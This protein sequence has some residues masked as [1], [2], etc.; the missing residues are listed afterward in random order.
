MTS[1]YFWQVIAE[2]IGR[3]F[4]TSNQMSRYKSKCIRILHVH[5]FYFLNFYM[6]RTLTHVDSILSHDIAFVS[7]IITCIKIDKSLVVDIS[8]NIMWR[9][10]VHNNVRCKN[11]ANF[12]RKNVFDILYV[13]KGTY[14]CLIFWYFIWKQRYLLMVD[15]L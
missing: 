8:C 5:E 1:N 14:W 15:I 13:N 9:F 10:D 7:D 3:K 11:Y 2:Y 6:C 12:S 4:L